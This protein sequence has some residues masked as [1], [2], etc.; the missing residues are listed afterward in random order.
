MK[1]VRTRT[2]Y[3]VY[4]KDGDITFIMEAVYE[5]AEVKSTEVIGFH[6]GKPTADSITLYSGKLKAVIPE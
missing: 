3:T 1:R 5:N 4:S 2:K 6:Y